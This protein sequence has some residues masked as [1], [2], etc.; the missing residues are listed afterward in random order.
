MIAGLTNESIGT[1]L[2]TTATGSAYEFDLGP[3][4]R[5]ITRH[6]AQFDAAEGFADV[7]TSTLRRDGQPIELLMIEQC[8]V[9]A[10]ARLW[11]QVRSDSIPTVRDTSPI[12][13][14]E[15]LNRQ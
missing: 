2:V 7:P 1:F 10:R 14:I 6:K 13:K 5:S 3:T 9:G 8:T 11:L 4:Y 15:E 12:M